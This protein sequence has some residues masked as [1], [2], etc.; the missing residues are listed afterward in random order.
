MPLAAERADVFALGVDQDQ[1]RP[2]IDAEP[3]PDDLV[4]VVDHRVLDPVLVDLLADV[5]GLALGLELGGVD[6][7]DDQLVLVF[8]LEG[9]EVGQDVVA[10]DAAIGPEVEQDDLA[11]QL[12]EVDRPG[13]VEPADSPLQVDPRGLA[14]E[15]GSTLTFLQT[16][17][18]ARR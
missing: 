13:G 2:A 11:A 8:L 9:G 16:S 4:G 17:G 3:V 14:K 6:A 12:F 15:A 18:T 5:L 1:G 10:V 7:D